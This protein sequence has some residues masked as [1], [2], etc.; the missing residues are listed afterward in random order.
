MK[1]DPERFLPFLG[2]AYLDIESYCKGEVEPMGKECEEPQIIALT[3]CL[4]VSIC[5][6]YLDGR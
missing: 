5:I 3:E 1:S 2:D 6:A 4:G